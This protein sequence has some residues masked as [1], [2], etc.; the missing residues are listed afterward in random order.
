MGLGERTLATQAP[1][2]FAGVA[3]WSFAE[4]R[5]HVALFHRKKGKPARLCHLEYHE[6]LLD[7]PVMEERVRVWVS[8]RVSEKRLQ[9]V[10]AV[11]RLVYRKNKY[12]QIPYGFAPPMEAF[13]RNGSLADCA[14]EGL[15]CASFVL[16]VFHTAKVDLV[17]Y[18]EWERCEGDDAWFEDAIEHLKEKGRDVEELKAQAA[19]A[20]R[21]R[22][23]HVVAACG[24][25]TPA[26][27]E[28]VRGE[29]GLVREDLRQTIRM[30]DA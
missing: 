26:S 27:W 6:H 10:S 11:A 28:A 15:T 7:E 14:S 4:G 29:S 21:F 9:Q 12:S 24:F 18:D 20:L 17:R 5:N 19:A 1:S 13:D 16:A 23:E 2:D 3:C 22:P 30:S 8:P 25:E